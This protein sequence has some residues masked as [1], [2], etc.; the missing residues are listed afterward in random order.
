MT[1]PVKKGR[2]VSLTTVGHTV[3]N[4]TRMIYGAIGVRYWLGTPGESQI[5]SGS[6][7]FWE[8]IRLEDK[9]PFEDSIKQALQEEVARR[10]EA[11]TGLIQRPET[12]STLEWLVIWEAEPD[13]IQR[14]RAF[15]RGLSRSLKGHRPADLTSKDMGKLARQLGVIAQKTPEGDTTVQQHDPE[16]RSKD[17]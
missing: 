4:E 6:A 13:T 15:E 14:I 11:E 1:E 17:T 9:H 16:R 12:L 2:Y 5:I 8:P 7:L 3:N 10:L